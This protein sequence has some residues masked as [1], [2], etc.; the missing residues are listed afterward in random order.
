MTKARRWSFAAASKRASSS[1][2]S[3]RLFRGTSRSREIAASVPILKGVRARTLL[4][5][6]Q[7]NIFRS[8]RRSWLILVDA[9]PAAFL[10]SRNASMSFVVIARASVCPK[11]M[12]GT[13]PGNTNLEIRPSRYALSRALT[14]SF[15]RPFCHRSPKASNASAVAG[16]EPA[17]ALAFDAFGDLWQKGRGKELVNARDNAYRLGRLS[18]FVLPGSVP[19]ITFGQTD[20][21]AITTND[22]DAF[23][24]FR[25]AAGLSSTT[26]NHDLRLLRKMFNWGIRSSVLAR[27]PFK[28]GTEAAISLE[29]EVPRNKRLEGDDDEARLLAAANDHLRALVIAILDTACR[30]GEL[31]SLQWRDV[32]LRRREIRV[33]AEKEKTRRERIIPISSRLMAVLEMRRLDPSGQSFGPDA[34]VFGNKVGE[35][36]KSVHTAWINACA[37]AGLKNFQLRDLRHEAGSRFDEAGMPIIYVSNMLGPVSYTHLTLP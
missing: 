3:R 14:N 9:S 35:H 33:R 12:G 30:P 15:P 18:K 26:I 5:I 19:P 32:S 16:V 25:K 34:Y 24:D 27:T 8:N 6:P 37:S 17:T 2:P 29:R 11:V 36:V 4:L 31:L 22:I 23:R 28:I 10:N 7:L 1:S 21:R 13:D 20:E